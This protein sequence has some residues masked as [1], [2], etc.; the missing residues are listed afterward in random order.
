MKKLLKPFA[1]LLSVLIAISCL[2]ACSEETPSPEAFL[3]SMNAS[4]SA[5]S[6]SAAAD[7]TITRMSISI[8]LSAMG[9]TATASVVIENCGNITH[10]TENST[11]MGST[12]FNEYY[13]VTE[14]T[15]QTTY[16]QNGS[17]WDK[18]V[19]TVQ[20]SDTPVDYY[21]LDL[22]FKD[23]NF[24]YNEDKGS[25]VLKEGLEFDVFGFHIVGGE[26]VLSDTTATIVANVEQE[27]NGVF[28]TGTMTISIDLSIKGTITLP[29]V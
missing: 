13:V 28:M 8:T 9:E 20:A 21:G 15:T 26:G 18:E 3:N 11:M 29:T 16:T 23:A 7:D 10:S 12:S 1:L 19:S 17:S 22:L 27:Q 6:A 4:A 25:Y 5:D 24:D 2:T 14:G